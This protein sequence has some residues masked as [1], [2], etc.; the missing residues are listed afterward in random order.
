[1]CFS[2]GKLI[3]YRLSSEIVTAPY[4]IGGKYLIV[5]PLQDLVK[6][7]PKHDCI[8]GVEPLGSH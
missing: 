8:L 2:F 7:L 5:L 4:Y 6:H 1:M 3:F